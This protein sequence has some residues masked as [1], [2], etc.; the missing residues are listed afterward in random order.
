MIDSFIDWLNWMI[1]WLIDLSWLVD[2]L[3]IW[4][5][6]KWFGY[7]WFD[8]LIWEIDWLIELLIQFVDWLIDWMN[9]WLIAGIGLM[10]FGPFDYKSNDWF[11]SMSS[12]ELADRLIDWFDLI[13]LSW[14]I[15]WLDWLIYWFCLLWFDLLG[16]FVW[17]NDWLIWWIWLDWL[18]RLMLELI[19]SIVD[20]LIDILIG[21]L[22][23]WFDLV[24]FD[25]RWI[26]LIDWLNWLKWLVCS[27]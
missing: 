14:L 8:W 20:W 19:I 22:V 6:L 4:Y 18:I 16:W 26:D 13:C 3:L 10:W 1:G 21:R 9:G 17:L 24:W 25:P 7:I 12:I 23:D 15:G 27:I 2:W 5:E 11:D